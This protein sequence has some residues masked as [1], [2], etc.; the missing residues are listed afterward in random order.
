MLL[1]SC[2]NLSRGYDADPLFEDVSFELHAGERIGFVGPNGAGK[3]TLLKVIAGLEYAD[4]GEAKLHAGARIGLLR[5]VAEFPPDRTV[6]EEARSAFDELL[7]VQKEFESVAE[8]LSTAHADADHKAL[9]DRF[10]RLNELLRTQDAYSL[11]HKIEAVLGGLGFRDADLDR[12]IV[13]FSGGQQRRLLLAK[14]LLS[15]PDVMLLDEPSNHLDIDTTEW[16]EG[17]LAQQ[18]QGMIVVSHDRF[19]LDRVATRIFELHERRITVFPGNYSSYVKLR[20]EKYEREFK[21]WEAQREYIER[22]EDYVRR[23]H[24]GQLAKQAQSRMKT[25]GKM[26]RLEKPTKVTGPAIRFGEVARSG[27]Y[28][29]QAEDLS[30][31][32]GDLHL[33]SDLSFDVARG[34][35]LGIMGANG[36]GKT[37][38]LRI[39]LGDEPPTRGK[40]TRGHLTQ[41]GYLDQHLSLLDDEKSVLRAVWPEPDESLTEQKMRDLLGAFG[42]H[43]KI[44]EQPIR[45]LS[46]G[47]RSRAALAR[48]T[49][50]GAN[51]LVLDEPTNHLDLWA[52]DALEEA[53][54]S[55]EGT[56]IVVSH[57]RYFLN[58]VCDL[59]IVFHGQRPE[60]VYGNY[61][62]YELMR[63][64]RGER[65]FAGWKEESNRES[66]GEKK[67]APASTAVAV[68]PKKKWKYPFKKIAE[69]EADIEVAER[70]IGVL[71]TALQDVELYKQADRFRETMTTLESTREKLKTMYEHWEEMTERGGG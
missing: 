36:S 68:K 71:E 66:P 25:L 65:G 50:E 54:R 18:P 24:Y 70:Q 42:L 41:I 29:F 26:E 12:A 6:R 43:G 28:V 30:K 63:A 34:R 62:T 67:S 19:F 32:F 55:F 46:G 44:V 10:D 53:V 8:Q 16:L 47:E 61:D 39:L 7:A 13:S 23:A 4:T 58:K 48:L 45:S 57:D 33:F 1:L 21:E 9:A 5:Q 56:V 64:N 69:I 51:V 60:V 40:V 2:K 15:S 38:L 3:T 59:L 37:T 14:L 27:D 31:S 17:Y 20:D 11:D 35:R 22:Q 52:C 49:V